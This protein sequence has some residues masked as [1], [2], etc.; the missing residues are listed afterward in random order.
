M[1]NKRR[2]DTVLRKEERIVDQNEYSYEL[3]MR[4][5]STTAC[6]RVPLYSIRVKMKDACG[7]SKC[8]DTSDIFSDINKAIVFFEKIVRNLATPIDLA[9]IVEDEMC[10]I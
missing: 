1:N 9:Y 3:I 7:V 10:D 5:G 4:E 6:W 8:A 2:S